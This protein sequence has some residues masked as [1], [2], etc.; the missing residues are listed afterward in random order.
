MTMILN[1]DVTTE[2]L[3]KEVQSITSIEE[4]QGTASGEVIP[5]SMISEIADQEKVNELLSTL[6]IYKTEQFN[7]KYLNVFNL[8]VSPLMLRD[9]EHNAILA[10]D[11]YTGGMVY[12]SIDQMSADIQNLTELVKDPSTRFVTIDPVVFACD[13]Y[14]LFSALYTETIG[15]ENAPNILDIKSRR[16]LFI[17]NLFEGIGSLQKVIDTY[18]AKITIEVKQ[19]PIKLLRVTSSSGNKLIDIEMEAKPMEQETA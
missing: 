4:V 7:P 5:F 18:D 12:T 2:E 3:P 17:L 11:F 13:S 15:N 9:T 6:L 14:V 19:E 16:S 1:S 8:G 10:F